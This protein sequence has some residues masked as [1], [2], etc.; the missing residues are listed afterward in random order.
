M[1]VL[2]PFTDHVGNKEQRGD[3]VT[4]Q[5]QMNPRRNSVG[6]IKTVS[7]EKNMMKHHLT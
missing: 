7:H 2:T 6:D 5:L 1:G 4:N 3:T